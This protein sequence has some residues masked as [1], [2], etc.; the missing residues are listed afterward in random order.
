MLRNVVCLLT[1]ACVSPYLARSKSRMIGLAFVT[2][3]AIG[4]A[5]SPEYPFR[6]NSFCQSFCFHDFK[7]LISDYDFMFFL[8]GV[9]SV[10]FF[11]AFHS[12]PVRQRV[13]FQAR[14]RIVLFSR[15]FP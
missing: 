10:F 14:E 8:Y 7:C 1:G 11:G 2:S 3:D 6:A 13:F 5:L 15:G 9:L 4:L 12:L